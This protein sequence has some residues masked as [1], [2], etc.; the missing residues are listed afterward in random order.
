[1]TQL[2]LYVEKIKKMSDTGKINAYF[3]VPDSIDA[4]QYTFS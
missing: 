4:S 3:S 1:M 2:H